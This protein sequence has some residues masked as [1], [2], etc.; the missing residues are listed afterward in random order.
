VYY[1]ETIF[2]EECFLLLKMLYR[3]MWDYF[4]CW[5][6][7]VT[8]T[9]AGPV[10]WYRSISVCMGPLTSGAPNNLI[11]FWILRQNIVYLYVNC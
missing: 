8:S 2:V 5:Y 6:S 10:L 11:V 7:I 1:R 9:F 3:R 4:H